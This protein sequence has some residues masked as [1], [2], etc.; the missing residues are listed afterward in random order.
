MYSTYYFQLLDLRFSSS[1][2][3]HI[4]EQRQQ[5]DGPDGKEEL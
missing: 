4:S 1:I 5:S 3:L 2:Q